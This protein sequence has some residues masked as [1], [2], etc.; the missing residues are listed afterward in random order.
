[1]A[2]TNVYDYR[3]YIDGRYI[4]ILQRSTDSVFDPYI[5][6]DEDLFE[7]PSEADSSAIYVRY[8][9]T[10][11][12]PTNEEADL[13]VVGLLSLALVHYVK[14][15]LAEDSGDE[16]KQEKQYNQFLKYVEKERLNRRGGIPVVMP[17][18]SGV[19]K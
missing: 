16:R 17:I 15:R 7:T 4:A 8:S 5:T 2:I 18:G 3:Y 12:R 10:Y 6:M 13:G 1:M 14:A 19:L 11:A 9:V